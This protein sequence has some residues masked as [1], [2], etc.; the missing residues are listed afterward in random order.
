MNTQ[1]AFFSSPVGFLKLEADDTH[2]VSVQFVDEK[3][4]VP[5]KTLV[6]S[7]ILKQAVSELTEYF[8]G[9]RRHFTVAVKH[10]GTDFQL[11]VWHALATIPY[12]KTVP[13]Q[14]VAIKVGNAKAVRAIGRTNG[15]NAIAIVVPCHRVIGKSGKMVGYASGVW[16][17]EWLLAHEQKYM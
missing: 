16:R 10:T 2:L 13:Y 8:S 12:G 11:S 4:F 3:G 14:D 7:G 9:K 15:L 6:V 1:Y 5:P 17:K